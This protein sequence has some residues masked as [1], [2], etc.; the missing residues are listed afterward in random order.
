M[1]I[2]CEVA[3]KCV[4]PV[5]R[6]MLTKELI[7]THNLKQIEVADL[8]GIS[9]PAVS[10]YGK[11]IRGQA[12]NLDKEE[13]IVSSIN[14]IAISLVKGEISHRDFVRQICEVCRIVRGRGLMC[15]LHKNFDP[16]FDTET[17][18]F[19]SDALLKCV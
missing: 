5:I 7:A 17:C 15:I 1:L 16:T 10:L 4:L 12:I 3:I 19:C 8:L 2:P 11:K 9:Q 6:A 13:D 18:N 14:N